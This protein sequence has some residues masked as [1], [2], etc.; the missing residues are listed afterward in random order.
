MKQA[1][2]VKYQASWESRDGE[3]H[4]V[5]FDCEAATVPGAMAQFRNM[6]RETHGLMPGEYR[7]LEV[8]RI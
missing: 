2:K 7:V 5:H 1:E 4:D 6:A 3:L 8:Y